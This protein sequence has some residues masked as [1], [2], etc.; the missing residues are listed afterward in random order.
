V[1]EWR[2][3]PT[4]RRLQGSA[5]AEEYT[6]GSDKIGLGVGTLH[7]RR[8]VAKRTINKKFHSRPFRGLD[9][10]LEAAVGPRRFPLA[11]AKWYSRAYGI[12][13]RGYRLHGVTSF[14]IRR[15]EFHA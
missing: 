11:T 5:L 10:R 13:T 1:L 9:G 2:G 8:K 3:A 7:Y 4:S 15:P 14:P 12:I 6:R